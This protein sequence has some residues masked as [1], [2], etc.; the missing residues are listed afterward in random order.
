MAIEAVLDLDTLRCVS[1]HDGAGAEPYLWTALIWVEIDGDQ[2]SYG[3]AAPPSTT[4]TRAVVKDTMKAGQRASVPA[5]QRHFTHTF[6]DGVTGGVGMVTVLLEQ[7]GLEHH[8]VKRGY[9]T[10]LAELDEVVGGFIEANDRQPDPHELDD[11]V[12]RIERRVK[13][14]IQNAMT[15]WEKAAVVLGFKNP[16]D[17]VD[18]DVQL[19]TVFGLPMASQPFTVNYRHTDRITTYPPVGSGSTPQPVVVEQVTAF[20]LDGRVQFRRPVPTRPAR[21]VPTS[22]R[23]IPRPTVPTPTAPRPRPPGTH[24]P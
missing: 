14:A 20:D 3:R 17:V 12:A 23:P 15:G 7:D 5:A 10:F 4:G 9:T 8:E 13:R 19:W 21:P 11:L 22:P 18:H 2:W 24:E 6:D 16:D 1:Q